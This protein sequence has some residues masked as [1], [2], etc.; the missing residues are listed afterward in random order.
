MKE[1]IRKISDGSSPHCAGVLKLGFK[2]A[3]ELK[4]MERQPQPE[5][6]DSYLT[7]GFSSVRLK[8]RKKKG[9]R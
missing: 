6:A 2:K 9:W 4:R 5:V 8:K 7:S 3:F 1:N